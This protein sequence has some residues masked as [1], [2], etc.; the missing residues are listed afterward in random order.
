MKTFEK[1]SGIINH[2]TIINIK[3]KLIDHKYE[4]LEFL[5]RG[6]YGEVYLARDT[7]CSSYDTVVLKEFKSLK[8]FEKEHNTMI[9]LNK[10]Q[11]DGIP[12][13]LAS[14]QEPP[15][16]YLAYE[17]LGESLMEIVKEITIPL[18]SKSVS[19]IAI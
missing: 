18:S 13:L 12:K 10:R 17:Y 5:A 2:P 16:Y 9:G 19:M 8:H 7:R 1:Y 15:S 4:V 3:M 6:G 14:A 11:I